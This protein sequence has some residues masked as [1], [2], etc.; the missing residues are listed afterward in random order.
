MTFKQRFVKEI[1][2]L[3]H[4]VTVHPNN[5]DIATLVSGPLYVAICEIETEALQPRANWRL[6]AAL[7]GVKSLIGGIQEGE[8]YPEMPF[9]EQ[10]DDESES[11]Y[12]ILDGMHFRVC[13]KLNQLPSGMMV[14]TIEEGLRHSKIDTSVAESETLKLIEAELKQIYAK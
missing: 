11:L 7:T 2:G 5:A 9:W 10:E 3:R 1:I 8:P 12:S 13:M 14:F 6:I 4:R